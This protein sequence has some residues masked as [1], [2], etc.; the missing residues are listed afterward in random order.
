MGPKIVHILVTFKDAIALLQQLS[1]LTEDLD[2]DVAVSKPL[3]TPAFT[4]WVHLAHGNFVFS[5]FQ[6]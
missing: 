5:F 6:L 1:L 3:K 2:V 4:F